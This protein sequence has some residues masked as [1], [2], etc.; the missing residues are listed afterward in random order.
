[1]KRIGMIIAIVGIALGL[2]CGFDGNS[3][4]QSISVRKTDASYQFKAS[5]PKKR[6]ADVITYVENTLKDGQL[7]GRGGISDS[8]INL[9][10]SIKFHLQSEPGFIAIEFK[11][12]GNSFGAYQKMERMCIGIKKRIENP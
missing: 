11:K 2:G 6:T 10:D 9:G 7:F 12:T 3:N 1:M 8:D 5:Y 4:R